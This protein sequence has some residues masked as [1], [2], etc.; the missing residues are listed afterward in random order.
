MTEIVLRG[1]PSVDRTSPRV[2]YLLVLAAAA[3]FAVNGAVSKVILTSGSMTSLRLTELR[4]TGAFLSLAVFLAVVAPNR[5]RI[6][7]D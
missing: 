7:R 3:L 6:A 4:A 1:P 5:L 2:G